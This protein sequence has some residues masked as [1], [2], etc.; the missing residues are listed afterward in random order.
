MADG[1]GESVADGFK[2]REDQTAYAAEQEDLRA[3]VKLLLQLVTIQQNRIITLQTSLDAVTAKV[4]VITKP[5]PEI[6]PL[7]S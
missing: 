5:A 2:K 1:L 4:D 3:K 7:T 6:I